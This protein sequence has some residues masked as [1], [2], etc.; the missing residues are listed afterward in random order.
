MP[1][2]DSQELLA[3][4]RSR[5]CQ[6]RALLACPRTCPVDEWVTPLREALGYL[7][8]LRDN[9]MRQPTANLRLRAETA[10]LL[11][12]VRQTGILLEQAARRG[13]RWLERLQ[14]QDGYTA[15]GALAPLAGRGCISFF[16]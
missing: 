13:G 14:V 10:A 7:E 2:G 16:G 6:A 12:E 5:V 3:A 9:L 11:G 4:A 8:W 1:A 15:Q